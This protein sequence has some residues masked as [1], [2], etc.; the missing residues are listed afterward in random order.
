MLV[1]WV[2]GTFWYT[3]KGQ[4]TLGVFIWER[5]QCVHTVTQVEGAGGHLVELLEGRFE[6]KLCLLW[7]WIGVFV[8][9]VG[10]EGQKPSLS[11]IGERRSADGASPG[12]A[13]SWAPP[14]CPGPASPAWLGAL[15]QP[16]PCT[17][18][19]VASS[20]QRAR[21]VETRRVP[22]VPSSVPEQVSVALPWFCAHP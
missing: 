8:W 14:A 5:S 17:G 12:P 3:G 7:F 16:F 20:S 4:E 15:R 6:T 2:M 19:D 13:R 18:Q 11:R 22:H 9:N 10:Y 1:F 21:S